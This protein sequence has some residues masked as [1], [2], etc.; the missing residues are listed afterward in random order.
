MLPNT[1]YNC[2][3]RRH[4]KGR[5]DHGQPH[6]PRTLSPSHS[7][8]GMGIVTRSTQRLGRSPPQGSARAGSCPGIMDTV[9][10]SHIDLL[11]P[12]DDRFKHKGYW[13]G[14]IRGL[15]DVGCRML[16]TDGAGRREG[17]QQ[18]WSVRIIEATR[19]RRKG[20]G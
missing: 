17:P 19:T 16:Y 14:P 7:L 1:R 15:L 13:A 6:P 5:L 8:P 12:Q 9:P 3:A 10:I 18:Q 2:M 20:N 11:Q 4:R